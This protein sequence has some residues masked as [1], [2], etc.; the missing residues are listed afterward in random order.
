MNPG[1]MFKIL[2]WMAPVLALLFYYIS[3]KQDV[4]TDDM[5]VE[6]AKFDEDFARMSEGL[7]EGPEKAEWQEIKAEAHARH[8]AA[9]ERA[10]ESNRK[11]DE[12]FSAMEKELTNSENFKDGAQ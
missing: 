3:Q 2:I 11:A 7:S 8:I 4:Q 1:G 5:K 12:T 6:F 10:E 9:H